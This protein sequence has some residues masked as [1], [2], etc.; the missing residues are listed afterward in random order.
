MLCIIA[1]FLILFPVRRRFIDRL[2]VCCEDKLIQ[3]G[4]R[5][6]DFRKATLRDHPASDQVYQL[7]AEVQRFDHQRLP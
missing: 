4:D 1:A 6:P 3:Y 2:L 5:R 7:I